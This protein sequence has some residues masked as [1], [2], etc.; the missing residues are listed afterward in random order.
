MERGRVLGL[1]AVVALLVIGLWAESRARI[2]HISFLLPPSQVSRELPAAPHP[3]RW[4]AAL[5]NAPVIEGESVRTGDAGRLEI[6]LECGSAVRL[7]PD[8]RLTFSRLRRHDNGDTATTLTL[9]KGRVFFNLRRA[10]TSD[11]HLDLA[12]ARLDIP[13]EGIRF[14]ARVLGAAAG[15]IAI[16]SGDATLLVHGASHDL[17]KSSG[18]AWSGDGSV[19]PL[20]AADETD[21]GAVWSHDRDREF[22]R[23]LVA[24]RLRTDL[25]GADVRTVPG[26]APLP[27]ISAPDSVSWSILS[28]GAQSGLPGGLPP[29]L[30]NAPRVP[31]CARY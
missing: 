15:S 5:L 1:A 28:A 29:V 16:A 24:G 8:S 4:T 30:A 12:G 6:Q 13:K 17:K 20:P 27:D 7:T 19:R 9:E 14:Q 26:Q 22:D 11:F 31:A 23:A 3:R 21:P 18:L 25:E 10:D 2:V